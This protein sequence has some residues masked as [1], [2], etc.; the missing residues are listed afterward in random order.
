MAEKLQLQPHRPTPSIAIIGMHAS[1][2][3]VLACTLANRL[4]SAKENGGVH[5]VPDDYTTIDTVQRDWAT[6]QAHDWP[7]STEE[8]K[9]INLRWRLHINSEI[10]C[11]MRLVDVSGQDLFY[12]F[13]HDR[14]RKPEEF[15]PEKKAVFEYCR[16]ANIVLFLLN[17][18]DF[19]GEGNPGERI[20]REAAMKA[21]MDCLAAGRRVCVVLTQ[22]EQYAA[23]SHRHGSW[24]RLLSEAVPFIYNAHLRE[25]KNPFSPS[26]GG[27]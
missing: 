6:L 9:M 18:G 12:I 8:G 21:A 7:K 17:L 25:K 5:L 15:T 13:S 4:V 27:L 20:S 2:K 14:A 1:G 11:E 10:S 19:L 16:S 22:A 24:E 23:E 26:F 3:T